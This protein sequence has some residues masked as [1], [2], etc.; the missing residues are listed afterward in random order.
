MSNVLIVVSFL[1]FFFVGNLNIKDAWIR[2]AAK[3]MN[4]ALYFKVENYSNKAD[5]LLSISSSIAE[6]VQMHETFKNGEMMGMREVKAVAIN[7]NST[8][9]FKPG[10][11]HIMVV[12]L[13]K[14]LRKND[15]AEFTLHFKNAGN[16][17]VK[18][19]VKM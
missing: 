7:P 5:T 18:A 14:T 1:S 11:H 10:D 2:P 9:E 13:K 16:I 19:S 6:V 3:G 17:N 8:F 12:G 15:S 4:T